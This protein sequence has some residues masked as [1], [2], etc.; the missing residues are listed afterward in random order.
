MEPSLPKCHQNI[1]GFYKFPTM[2]THSLI[3]ENAYC[4]PLVTEY[5]SIVGFETYN[6]GALSVTY[7]GLKIQKS[8]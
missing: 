6:V 8:E 4:L 2:S 5:I 1:A 3:Q 7:S